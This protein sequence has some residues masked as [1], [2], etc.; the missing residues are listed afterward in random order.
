MGWLALSVTV[1]SAVDDTSVS[2]GDTGVVCE[3]P[4]AVIDQQQANGSAGASS[5]TSVGVAEGDANN[6]TDSS[7]IDSDDA[8]T[9]LSK[10]GRLLVWSAVAATATVIVCWACY[11]WWLKPSW[12]AELAAER[13]RAAMA[14]QQA[15]DADQRAL[16][17][18]RATEQ[19]T[20]QRIAAQDLAA[21]AQLVARTAVSAEQVAREEVGANRDQL[22][23]LRTNV[24]DAFRVA[25][26]ATEEKM[27]LIQEVQAAR[28]VAHA[29]AEDKMMLA[30]EVH[31]AAGVASLAA[32]ARFNE[33]TQ[34]LAL[35]E[36]RLVDMQN[37]VQKAEVA[38]KKVVDSGDKDAKDMLMASAVYGYLL[39]INQ[40]SACDIRGIEKE[41]KAAEHD[42]RQAIKHALATYTIDSG[43]KLRGVETL[44]QLVRAKIRQFLWLDLGLDYAFWQLSPDG[45]AQRMNDGFAEFL[46]PAD[47]EKSSTQKQITTLAVVDRE[48]DIRLQ[49]VCQLR[50]WQYIN[51]ARCDGASTLIDELRNKYGKGP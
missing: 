1:A 44:D 19:E 16:A 33:L 41:Y 8:D 3:Q 39:D 29:A 22:A 46:S 15:N 36:A 17:A 18:Q 23:V 6:V 34:Q 50:L 12:A 14:Q 42:F 32:E 30:Q 51:Q 40:K 13:Q 4:V 5:T 47:D 48:L 26:R 7:E 20:A 28:E 37:Q 25:V 45:R 38:V 2:S 9:W 31:A 10:H 49:A 35:A 21:A 43:D 11:Q 27:M 24:T